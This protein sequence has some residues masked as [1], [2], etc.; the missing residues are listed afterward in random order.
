MHMRTLK[1][2]CTGVAVLLAATA[3]KDALDVKNKNNPDVAR[4]YSTPAG[5]EGVISNT[6]LQAFTPITGTNLAPQMASMSFESY[7]ALSNFAM[8]TRSALPRLPISN[9]RGNQTATEN[10]NTFSGLQRDTRTAANGVQALDKL[11]SGGGTLGSPAQNLRARAF[12]FFSDGVAL[13]N[14][15]LAYDSA[16]IVTPAV[17]SDVVPDLSSYQDVNKAAL[18]MLDTAIAIAGQAAA[19]QSGGF[20]LPSTWIN[21]NPM[22]AAQFIRF[23]RSYKA[24]FRAG[25]ARTP[26]ERAAVDWNAVIADGENGIQNDI[27]VHLDPS[28]GW[29]NGWLSQAQ[30]YTGWSQMTP[31]ILG[32]ADTSGAYDAWLAAPLSA[33][34]PFLIQTPDKRFPSGATRAAQVTN[35]PSVPGNTGL[36]FRNR[37]GGDQPGDA[38]GQSFY[39]NFRFLAIKNNQN[40]G[41]WP[42]F[43]QAENDMLVAEGYIRQNNFAKAAALIDKTRV[44]NNLPALSGKITS[45]NDV[46]P[47]GQGCVPHVPAASKNFQGTV[48]G[49]I[50][51]AMKYEKRMETSFTGFGQWY[52]DSRG[53]GD[54]PEGTALQW[55]VPYQEMDARGHPFYDLGGGLPSS[56]AK[57]SYGL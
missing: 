11:V 9:A 51:E 36:Y 34:A 44:K 19:S 25:V 50:F 12:A 5:I 42:V 8:A 15:S 40:V 18:A 52:F 33:R 37:N 21:G 57:G 16:A 32:M 46:V 13:G 45:I 23:A 2:T 39:D 14:L 56:A 38:W 28:T 29:T 49:N 24:R 35:S 54:L 4:A 55:P 1:V 48:C 3:C 47:G 27:N 26:A 20:P 7:A 22:T 10:F 17:S 43:T 53:W 41:D 30:V 6:Y 31:M